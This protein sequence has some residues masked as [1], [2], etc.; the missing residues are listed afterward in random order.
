MA[1]LKRDL[2]GAPEIS[3]KK[4]RPGFAEERAAWDKDR[5]FN[6][7]LMTKSCTC[8]YDLWR[9]SLRSDC[10]GM[11]APKKMITVYFVGTIIMN[12]EYDPE[13]WLPMFI[14]M[15]FGFQ[16]RSFLSGKPLRLPL[17]LAITMLKPVSR[18]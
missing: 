16:K 11:K 6:V 18:R 2:A 3:L 7:F 1:Q 5:P 15:G 8:G 13:S 17:T 10:R 12:Y 9:K 4:Y 14:T